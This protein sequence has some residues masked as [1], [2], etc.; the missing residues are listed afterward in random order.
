MW[1]KIR[2]NIGKREIWREDGEVTNQQG[3]ADSHGD[4]GHHHGGGPVSP[5]VGDL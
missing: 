4:D 1:E 3:D 5:K 2:G